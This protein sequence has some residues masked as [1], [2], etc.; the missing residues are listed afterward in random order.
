MSKRI[1][2]NGTLS[3][4]KYDEE[5]EKLCTGNFDP[6]KEMDKLKALD[7]HQVS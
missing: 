7:S 6:H 5:Y 2:G 3:T 1:K 4:G